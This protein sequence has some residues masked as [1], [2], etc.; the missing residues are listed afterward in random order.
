M[1]LLPHVYIFIL[2]SVIRAGTASATECSKDDL[3]KR[4]RVRY[5][6][7]IYIYDIPDYLLQLHNTHIPNI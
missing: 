5:L 1:Q 4:Q 7:S 6:L 2:F 3:K